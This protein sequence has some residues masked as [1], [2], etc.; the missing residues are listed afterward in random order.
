MHVLLSVAVVCNGCS[1]SIDECQV[2]KG[3]AHWGMRA[4]RKGWGTGQGR[5]RWRLQRP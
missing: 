3:L 2:N 1:R 4:A 5:W